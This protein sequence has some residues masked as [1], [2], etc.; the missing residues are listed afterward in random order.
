MTSS[1]ILWEVCQGP[2][3]EYGRA[4]HHKGSLS[5][6]WVAYPPLD[7]WIWE[8]TPTTL[9]SWLKNEKYVGKDYAGYWKFSSRENMKEEF[10][11]RN[12]HYNSVRGLSELIV[13]VLSSVWL[14]AALPG[15]G[16]PPGIAGKYGEGKN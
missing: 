5:F 13:G 2:T 16:V 7:K 9:N 3:A 12:K 15:P 14:S 11:L 4:S 1:L 8:R 6:Q 10:N